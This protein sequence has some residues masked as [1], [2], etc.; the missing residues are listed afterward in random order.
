MS[1][2]REAASSPRNTVPP[3]PQPLLAAIEGKLQV[4]VIFHRRWDVCRRSRADIV[5]NR[6]R[7]MSVPNDLRVRLLP[8][9]QFGGFAS[10]VRWLG[11]KKSWRLPCG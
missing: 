8:T 1:R 2:V 9:R 7:R 10:Y 11:L 5:A 3:R 4:R 6:E